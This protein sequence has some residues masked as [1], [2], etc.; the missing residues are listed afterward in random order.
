MVSI[1]IHG[2]TQATWAK[3]EDELQP[4][5]LIIKTI[6]GTQ[7]IALFPV[8]PTKQEETPLVA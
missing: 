5:I 7:E 6:H 8:R 2:V 3:L 1:Q 4:R